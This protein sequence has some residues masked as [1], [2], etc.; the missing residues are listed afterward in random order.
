M[1]RML[2]I[3]LVLLVAIVLIG[4]GVI[5]VQQKK[6]ELSQVGT[7]GGK[8][9][10]VTVVKAE[11]G[12]LNIENEYLAVV[13]PFEEARISAR[14]TAQA[15]RILVDEGDWVET[16]SM[17]AELDAEE[18]EHRIASAEASIEQTKADLSSSQA[19]VQALETT[20]AYWQAEKKRDRSLA[21]KGAISRA[22][23]EKTM[24]KAADVRG[25]LAA[26]RQKSRAL[27]KQI[28]A[29]QQQ[30]AELSTRLGYYTLTSPFSGRV[31]QRK[32]DAG[33]LAA[34]GQA[35]FVIQNQNRLKITFDVPQKDLPEVNKTKT[36]TFS[37]GGQT[38]SAR[39]SL[40]HPALDKAKMMRAEAWPEPDIAAGLT[41]GAYLPVTV[42]IKKLENVILVPE[43]TLIAGPEGKGHVFAVTD[44]SLQAKSVEV[45]G[46][47]GDRAAIKGI[48]TGTRLVENT[49]LGWATLSSGQKVETVQ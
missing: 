3:G 28:V 32:V 8:P 37:A 29:R 10:P 30:K 47:S 23:A 46:S 6:K 20:H 25:K 4:G 13:E 24:E 16:G 35:L 36:V 14:V 19:T 26:A 31:S 2:R 27:Q 44:G 34:P 17:L 11:K 38:R 45:L 41:P 48:D 42:L 1:R 21:D 40:M 33:D 49:Y 39:I 7:Y 9:R 15:K 43:S 22:Q 18:L 5:L 12:E